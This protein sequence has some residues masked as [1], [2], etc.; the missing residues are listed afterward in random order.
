MAAHIRLNFLLLLATLLLATSAHAASFDCHKAASPI[1]KRICADPDLDAL[2]SQVEAAFQGAL[3]RSRRPDSVREGQRVWLKTRDGCGDARCMK[4][5]YQAR[6]KALSAMADEPAVCSGGSTPEVN[7][8]DAA[9]GVWAD[10]EL[11]RYVAAVR[12]KLLGEAK[13]DP[14]RTAPKEALKDFDQAQTAWA[15]YRKAECGGI[16]DWWSEGTIRGAMYGGCYLAVTKA[17]SAAI[18]AN[19][20]TPME[21]DGFA[22]MPP[23]APE[24]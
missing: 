14:G 23:P 16:Y 13:D 15:A 20:L 11:A 6:V 17:R 12:G 8:C 18:L 19:W 22:V 4:A 24:T 7:E 5:A 10:K 3:D 21:R 9:H 2:D 1:E